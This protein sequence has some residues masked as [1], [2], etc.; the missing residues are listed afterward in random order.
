MTDDRLVPLVV[1]LA[2]LA[3]SISTVLKRSL[4]Q[5]GYFLTASELDIVSREVAQIV[6]MDG[7]DRASDVTTTQRVQR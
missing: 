6:V 4:E 1:D 3:P 7:E 2:T 5:F